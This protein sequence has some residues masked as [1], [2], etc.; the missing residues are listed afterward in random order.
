[1]FRRR[2]IKQQTGAKTGFRWRGH[3]ISRIEGLSDAV[4]AF[5]ITLLVVSL[6]VPRTFSEL[7]ETMR[8]FFAF[9]ITFVILFQVWFAQYLF[10]RRYAL[11]D[12]MS[13]VLNGILLFVVLFYIYPLKFLRSLLMNELQ[14]GSDIV[15]GH[16]GKMEPMIEPS[17]AP[18]L[19]TIYGAGFIAVF[20][21][22]ALLYGHAYRKRRELGLNEF[23]I[24]VTYSGILPH[25]LNTVVGMVALL[26]SLAPLSNPGFASGM[27]YTI[28]LPIGH[29]FLGIYRGRKRRLRFET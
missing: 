22:F 18:L 4:F 1:M 23:E 26:V 17:Q 24:F 12:A 16:D 5:A 29:T 3:E 8:G 13:V 20:G 10:F 9:A 2:L 7:M 11:V 27:V 19:M 21:I 14:H 28:G 15:K 25:A 6:E